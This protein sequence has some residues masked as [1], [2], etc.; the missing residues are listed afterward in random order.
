MARYKRTEAENGQ[1]IFL[2]VNLKEQLLPDTF[3]HMLDE[4]INT[5]IDTE[6]FDKKYKNDLTGASAIPPKAL[7]KLV[8]YG[9]SKGKKSSRG[10]WELSKNNI[11]AKALSND[12]NIHWT[13][14][15]DF[16]SENSAEF[17]NIFIQVLA[18]C[19]E[20]GLVGG[21]TFAIDGLRLPSN[22]SIS[23]SGTKEQLEKRLKVYQRMA[24]KHLV[25]HKRKD[26]SG[27]T[28]EKTEKHFA[29]RQKKLKQQIEKLSGFLNTMEKK[30]GRRGKEIQ[31]NAT[32][33]ES[34][35]ILGPSGYI[36][37]YIGLAVSDKKEQIIVS[38][39]AVG[40]ANEG[41]HFPGM[42]D[43]TE[44]NIK[45]TSSVETWEEKEKTFL[46]DRNYFSEDN[47]K[48]S[49][50]RG[51][52]AIIPDSQYKRRLGAN[53][54][55]LYELEDFIYVKNNDYYKCP[56]G[57]KLPYKGVDII[58]NDEVKYYR[59]SLTDCR[60]CPEYN[61]CIRTKKERSMLDKGKNLVVRKSN[62]HGSL[63]RIMRKK[64]DT[65]E[66]QEKYAQRIQII[67][68][69]FANISYCKGLDRFTLR[70]KEKVNGQWR[71]Y[72]IMHNL[73]KC[74]KAYNKERGCA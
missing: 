51:I 69:V 10:I 24:E 73:G 74:L 39:E 3:E 66:Y 13:T 25:R 43:Q 33:N 21:G 5:K 48:A 41:E 53:K 1:G 38:A 57:K 71:L 19:N 37:G 30:E 63:C 22:A 7:L 59:A 16:I 27:E 68:P 9:Y 65:E 32:D 31:S 55:K 42:L 17:K 20:L 54:E 40:S 23:L 6:I 44:E 2:T 67:E 11:I 4:I 18:Y 15:A 61:K 70:G 14:I 47:L 56:Q 29:E 60:A 50:E 52:E 45:K 72:C 35:V 12:I 34:A 58:D 46:A 28:D 36:Q 8:I 26:E 49:E 62:D 64:L